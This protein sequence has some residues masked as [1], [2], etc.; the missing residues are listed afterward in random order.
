M[1]YS[2]LVNLISQQ[3]RPFVSCSFEITFYSQNYSKGFVTFQSNMI[4]KIFL[5]QILLNLK[6]Y[7]LCHHLYWVNPKSSII[8]GRFLRIDHTWLKLLA[9]LATFF[10]WESIDILCK[11]NMYMPVVGQTSLVWLI[12]KLIQFAS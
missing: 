2:I 7:F 4:I 5:T 1:Q 9:L 3:Q 8:L 11:F 6:A 12:I 10:P